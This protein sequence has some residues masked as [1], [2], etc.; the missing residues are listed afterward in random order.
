MF[1][2]IF[3]D[4]IRFDIFVHHVQVAAVCFFDFG[5]FRSSRAAKILAQRIGHAIHFLGTEQKHFVLRV[6]TANAVTGVKRRFDNLHADARVDED[7]TIAIA[8]DQ[9]V[10]ARRWKRRSMKPT[11]ICML[12]R[13]HEW[14]CDDLIL[15]KDA[16]MENFSTLGI[17]SSYV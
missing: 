2:A 5:K 16:K 17:L 1:F 12:N 4:V 15:D 14:S 13:D 8:H 11:K 3:R 9:A 6:G 10:T 7:N